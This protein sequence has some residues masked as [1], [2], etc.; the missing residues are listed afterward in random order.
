[1]TRCRNERN[2]TNGAFEKESRLRETAGQRP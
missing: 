2:E 1:M